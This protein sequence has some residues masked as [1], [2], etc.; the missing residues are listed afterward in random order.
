MDNVYS[1]IQGDMWDIIAW[2]VY[3]TA[4]Y[5]HVLMQANPDHIRTYMFGAGVRLR[6]PV[7]SPEE[8]IAANVPPWRRN[9]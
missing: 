8:S 9:R 4:K 1:T 6:V 5:V 2:R 3:G 7:L